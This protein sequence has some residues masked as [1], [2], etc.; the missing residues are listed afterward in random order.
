M[1]F[2]DGRRSTSA[3]LKNDRWWPELTDGLLPLEKAEVEVFDPLDTRLSMELELS[4]C[5]DRGTCCVSV[6]R[7][8]III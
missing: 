8:E 2:A 7:I 6:S 1:M 5:R 3:G 4:S